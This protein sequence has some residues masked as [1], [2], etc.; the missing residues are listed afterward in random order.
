[1][2]Q[3]PRGHGEDKKHVIPA[4]AGIQWQTRIRMPDLLLT[5]ELCTEA[6]G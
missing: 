1:M 6:T 4:Q 2:E 3:L 5:I